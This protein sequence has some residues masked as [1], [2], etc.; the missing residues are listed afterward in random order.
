MLLFLIL[1]QIYTGLLVS[2]SDNSCGLHRLIGRT[3]L[4]EA[5]LL[6]QHIINVPVSE[7]ERQV[8][9]QQ[10]MVST[11]DEFTHGSHHAAAAALI[12]TPD[13]IQASNLA[14]WN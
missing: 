8:V 9:G 14:P 7:G 10:L 6:Q 11:Q 13:D 12:R 5:S 3:L 1:A 2:R 4:S